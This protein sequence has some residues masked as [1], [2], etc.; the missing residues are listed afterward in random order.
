MAQVYTFKF[1]FGGEPFAQHLMPCLDRLHWHIFRNNGNGRL[2]LLD[3]P[4]SFRGGVPLPTRL[5]IPGA[6]LVSLVAG[7]W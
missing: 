2:G 4:Q 1:T 5:V 6:R 7:G 3:S